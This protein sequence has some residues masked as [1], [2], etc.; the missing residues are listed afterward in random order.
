[1]KRLIQVLWMLLLLLNTSGACWQSDV[2][3]CCESACRIRG[4]HYF[5]RD[6]ILRACMRSSGCSDS[7]TQGATVGMRCDC[8]GS[9]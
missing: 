7:E 6:R 5:E 8:G 9:K 4:A 1:M 3:T 2:R